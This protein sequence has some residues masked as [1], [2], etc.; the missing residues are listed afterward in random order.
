MITI[1]FLKDLSKVIKI[2]SLAK[3][4]GLNENTTYT[5]FSRNQALTTDE[6]VALEKALNECGLFIKEQKKK[7]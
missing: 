1:Q 7:S 3:M 4:A 5:K 6:S 2:K